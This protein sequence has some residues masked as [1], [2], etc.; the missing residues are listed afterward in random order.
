MK[1]QQ[2]EIQ[3]L[4]QDRVPNG[5]KPVPYPYETA[6]LDSLMINRGEWKVE[7][8]ENTNLREARKM[9]HCSYLRIMREIDHE[10]AK[11]QRVELRNSIKKSAFIEKCATAYTAKA[12]LWKDLDLDFE[13]EPKTNN[14]T[15]EVL[16]VKASNV[17]DKTID[18]LPPSFRKGR[19]K[20]RPSR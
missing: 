7:L 19:T 4:A 3:I 16:R 18:T 12:S 15:E 8:P 2:E 5:M 1:K 14:I 20:K 11:A 17:Y 13:D 10:I 6:F 9:I